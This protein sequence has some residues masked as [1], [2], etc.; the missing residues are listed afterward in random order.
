MRIDLDVLFDRLLPDSMEIHLRPTLRGLLVPCGTEGRHRLHA[1]GRFRPSRTPGL[2]RGIAEEEQSGA[3]VF[4]CGDVTKVLLFERGRVI[5][6]RSSVPLEQAARIVAREGVCTKEAA[7]PLY[8]IE[9]QQGLAAALATLPDD[10]ARWLGEKL[11]W[12]IG[13]SLYFMGRGHWIFVEGTPLSQELP[14]VDVDP[15]RLSIV[16]FTQYDEWRNG[17]DV[18]SGVGTP[19]LSATD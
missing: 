14:D 5:A 8:D 19:A 4:L 1:I 6:A 12:E 13:T 9:A 18:T 7:E 16:G 11:V 2:L 15:F 3:L 17:G 10:I